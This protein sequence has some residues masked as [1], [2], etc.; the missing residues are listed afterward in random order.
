MWYS[1][2]L[3]SLIVITSDKKLINNVKKIVGNSISA[4][5]LWAVQE[6]LIEDV[7]LFIPD[8][9]EKEIKI[10]NLQGLPPDIVSLIHEYLSSI[11]IL[12]HRA[13]I[14]LPEHVYTLDDLHLEICTIVNQLRYLLLGDESLSRGLPLI[15]ELEKINSDPCEKMKFL[16]SLIDQ[17]LQINSSLSYVSTQFYS[18]ISPILSHECPIR[19]FSLLGIGTGA[20]ALFKIYN[21][22]NNI[23]KKYAIPKSIAEIYTYDFTEIPVFKNY[24]KYKPEDWRKFSS[25]LDGK[26]KY[27]RKDDTNGMFHLTYF[28]G[29]QGFR[30]SLHGI[31][32][33]LQSLSLGASK[34]WTLLT[35]THEFLHA[36]VRAIISVLFP[37]KQNENFTD[38]YDIFKNIEAVAPDSKQISVRDRLAMI[39]LA[40]LQSIEQANILSSNIMKGESREIQSFNLSHEDLFNSYTNNYKIVN[41]FLVHPLDFFYFY[42]ANKDLYVKLVWLTWATNPEIQARIS[43]YLLRTLITISLDYRG[44]LTD[45]F[46]NSIEEIKKSFNNIIE[47]GLTRDNSIIQEALAY[48]NNETRCSA[49]RAQ[50]LGC[51]RLADMARYLLHSNNVHHDIKEDRLQVQD[52]NNSLSYQIDTFE[53]QDRDIRSPIAFITHRA[54]RILNKVPEEDYEKLL[55]ETCWEL[56]IISSADIGNGE[57]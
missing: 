45:R 27:I 54:K 9:P 3:A 8:V 33:A 39:I 17:I 34:R 38:L 30:E 52:E 29:Q 13:L 5:E 47:L 19:G 24:Y 46:N 6:N 55:K 44:T 10:P 14:Y 23:F 25:F 11:K 57:K 2:G 4:W 37:E 28:S 41:E 12:I 16:Q 7:D 40:N 36:H 35:L 49:L 15:D 32:A 18:G 1:H 56:I 51:V 21:F 42:E 48:L 50:F 43:H 53:F 22:V 31:S 20:K 26:L